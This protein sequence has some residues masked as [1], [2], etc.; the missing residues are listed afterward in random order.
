M[1]RSD[2]PAGPASRAPDGVA[3]ACDSCERRCCCW[4]CG[5]SATSCGFPAAP[6]T[7]GA[8]CRRPSSRASTQLWDRFDRL[9]ARSLSLGV[10]GLERALTNQTA[11][12][13]D[14]VIENYRTPLPTVRETQW[15]MAREA[16]ARALAARPDDRRL[17][18][19]LRYCEGHLHRINGEARK[20]RKLA[21]EAQR[22]F[23]E[24]VVG[25]PGSRGAA[26]EL[27]RS[28][29]RP[30][31]D[32]HLRSGRRR[33]RR[34]RAE[35]GAALRVHGRGSRDGAA[36]RRLSIARATRWRAPRG[37]CREWRR[38]RNT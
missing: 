22:E 17:K 3:P 34:R 16:L 7:Q 28:V 25:V 2:R 18:G 13:A 11:T 15:K 4:R 26:S 23:T 12:L 1:E 21:A 14:R 6:A 24:A 9:K 37:R 38:N 33:P 20:A 19:A 36:G 30:D 27:A 5:L 31:A 29:S 8:R 10:I 32:V 35:A